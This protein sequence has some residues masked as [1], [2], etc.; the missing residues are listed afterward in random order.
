MSTH[1]EPGWWIASHHHADSTARERPRLL[2]RAIL[3]LSRGDGDEPLVL[4]GL[5]QQRRKGLGKLGPRAAEGRMGSRAF[6]ALRLPDPPHLS[7]TSTPPRFRGHTVIAPNQPPRCFGG[8][9][10]CSRAALVAGDGRSSHAPGTRRSRPCL[11]GQY[12]SF[13]S[14]GDRPPSRRILQPR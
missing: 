1:S 10:R 6:P 9:H 5:Q 4:L 2:A 13:N 14:D 7:W 8:P 3:G 11:P 12:L